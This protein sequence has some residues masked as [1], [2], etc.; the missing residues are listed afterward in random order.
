MDVTI[1]RCNCQSDQLTVID[2]PTDSWLS[3]G[4]T[5]RLTDRTTDRQTD[6]RT[7]ARYFRFSKI[8]N[9]LN[10]SKDITMI[11]KRYYTFIFTELQ[12]MY[13]SLT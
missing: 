3:E 12:R 10:I 9:I 13:V 11:F 6:R 5:E 7:R 4:T 8:L 2:G 1:N